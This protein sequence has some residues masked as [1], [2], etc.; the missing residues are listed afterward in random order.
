VVVQGRT[1]VNAL[2]T[3][4]GKFVPKSDFVVVKENELRMVVGGHGS[5]RKTP[6]D[7]DDDTILNYLIIEWAPE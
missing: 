2:L 1:I 3:F 7:N 6:T 4:E 5:K